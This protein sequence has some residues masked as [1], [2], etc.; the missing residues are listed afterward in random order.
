MWGLEKW[1]QVLQSYI[2]TL[3]A[4]DTPYLVSHRAAHP[5]SEEARV[6]RDGGCDVFDD[7][8]V[9]G[10]VRGIRRG[11]PC[12]QGTIHRGAA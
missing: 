7:E 2:W 1:G 5:R 6:E 9:E 11:E 12:R 10:T 4:G 8:F 3:A